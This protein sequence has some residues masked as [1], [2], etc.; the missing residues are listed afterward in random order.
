MNPPSRPRLVYTV[1]H[2]VTADLFLRGQ[3]AF[4]RESG[5]D[6]TVIASPGRELE[7]AAAREG[8]AAVGLP[9]KRAPSP[10]EDAVALARMIAALRRLQPDIV[11]ASTPKAGMLGMLAAR[12]L[13]VPVKI[14][15]LRGLRLETTTGGLR[16]IL[17][18][19]EKLTAAAA[20]EVACVSPSLLRAAVA[21]GWVPSTKAS[22]VGNGTSNGVDVERFCR[23]DARVAEG[24]RL[25]EMRGVPATAPTIGFVG[26]LARDKG[27]TELLAAF[28]RVRTELPDA[29]L[30]LL[31]G[32]IGDE[33][34]DPDLA[35]RARSPNV[36]VTETIADL[37]P[38]YARM[39][40]LA[41]PSHREGFPNA[42]LE[43][44]ACEV[45]VVG[46]RA[47]GVVDA[48]EDGRTGTLV[49]VGDAAGL[50]VAL[51]AYLRDPARARAHGRAGRERVA[52][53]FAPQAVWTAWLELFHRR[54]GARR[55]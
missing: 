54:L 33:A 36:V 20:D 34:A 24:T 14:Y 48:I 35:A 53:L 3:L 26:R 17:A 21:G 49:D 7:R 12:V 38:Y 9:M 5:F 42:P 28:A 39:D 6:V 4:M 16:R 15:L 19:T 22:V 27:I 43:A 18:A 32:D 23:T 25:L 8:V 51:L 41:F 44:A 47:T 55:L 37:A 13:R 40:V 11:V 46:A 52:R 31:G 2:P 30:L 10:A 29:R 45:P 1:T 50:A